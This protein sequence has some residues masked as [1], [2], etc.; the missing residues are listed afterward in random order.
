MNS[1]AYKRE[2]HHFMS[3]LGRSVELESPNFTA[4]DLLDVVPEDLVRYL[5]L[6]AYGEEYP[7]PG[8]LP[9]Y[10]RS[11]TLKAMKKMLSSFM[12]R[13]MIQWDDI[14]REGN[15]TKSIAVN[16][17]IKKVM[18]H[19]VRKQGVESCAR[20][21]MEFDEYINAL[22]I[23]RKGSEIHPFERFRLSAVLTLQ[24]HLIGRVDDMM[25][26]GF[27]DLSFNLSCP[28]SLICQLRWSKNI[29]EE[30]EA[31]RQIIFA[32]K[33]DRMCPL[34]NLAVFLELC[35]VDDL[36]TNFLFGN[37]MDGDRSIRALLARALE[38]SNFRKLGGGKLGTHSIRKGAATY[39]AKC[40]VS[41]DHVELRGRWRGQKRQVDTY[42]DIERAFPD[43]QVAARLCGP[44]GAVR[45][46]L[47]ENTWVSPSILSTVIAPN[48]SRLL[49]ADIG[50][51]LALPLMYAALQQVSKLDGSFTLLPNELRQRILSDIRRCSSLGDNTDIPQL[52]DVISITPSGYNG[53]LK[54]VDVVASGGDDN[55]SFAATHDLFHSIVS[56]VSLLRSRLE[57]IQSQNA[58]GMAQLES[59]LVAKMDMI[60]SSV[61][62]IAIQPVVRAA[63]NIVDINVPVARP[64][65]VACLSKRPKDLYD[66]WKEY[67]FGLAGL[68]P[69][70]L[71]NYK[72]RG[73]C[74]FLYCVRLKFW[75]LTEKLIRRGHTSDTAIDAI[76]LKYGRHSSVTSILTKIR[77]SNVH[78]SEF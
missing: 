74:K 62:R 11:N 71:F 63:S 48:C 17:V 72:E 56:E 55:A 31:P 60:N 59:I 69:A 15:P 64:A 22:E 51:V 41:K 9:T 53:Q 3:F 54:V 61:R 20:R 8:S 49:G 67:E 2:L 10:A 43:A 27:L 5:N 46:S 45:Y 40:G 30:R 25:K 19:E 75:S 37:G 52:I 70:K 39:C 13:R 12:P 58:A 68:K 34:L 36:N 33:D 42:I 78:E 14:R 16:E 4:N 26:M 65:Q 6:K 73:A 44:H 66:L 28:F 47:M 77:K 1:K 7:A 21:P 35:P 57:E 38:D 23:I 32:S 18:K 29:T 50:Q 24:W 76:Y